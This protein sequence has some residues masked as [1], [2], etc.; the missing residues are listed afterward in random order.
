MEP[1]D[2]WFLDKKYPKTNLPL[3]R[4]SE[5]I[6]RCLRRGASCKK[7]E[8]CIMG[9]N[10]KTKILLL[11]LLLSVLLTGVSFATPGGHGGGSSGDGS[12][13]GQKKTDQVKTYTRTELEDFFSGLPDGIRELVIDKQEGKPR[14]PAQLNLIRNIFLDADKFRNESEAAMW[15]AYEEVAVVLDQAGQNAEL[16]L[17]VTTGGT[18]TFVTQTLFGATRAGVNEYSKGKSTEDIL[19]AVA[20]AVSVDSIMSNVGKLKNIGDRGGKLVDMVSRAAKLNKNPKVAKYL[21]K[22]GIKAGVYKAGEKL[23]KD[24]IGAILN[25]MATG[26]RKIEVSNSTPPTYQG[27][28]NIYRNQAGIW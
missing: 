3:N 26:V 20:V 19:Q 22:V 23:T 18:S 25:A 14:T 16:V 8:V 9:K 13:A 12:T 15:E 11:A 21:M 28:P 17:A 27:N 7:T 10:K 4:N 1:T 2:I 24:A 5:R 6:P